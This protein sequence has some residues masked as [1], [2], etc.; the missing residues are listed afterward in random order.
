MKWCMWRT[1]KSAWD[2]ESTRK[3]RASTVKGY[4][5][6]S[7]LASVRRLL[8][9]W[10]GVNFDALCGPRLHLWNKGNDTPRLGLPVDVRNVC[11]QWV[12]AYLLPGCPFSRGHDTAQWTLGARAVLSSPCLLLLFPSCMCEYAFYFKLL[13]LL[14]GEQIHCSQRSSGGGGGVPAVRACE[15]GTKTSL[16]HARPFQLAFLLSLG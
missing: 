5:L 6:W 3:E 14:C 11:S 13:N 2:T 9:V 4:R 12:G 15:S 16:L 8:A 1:W 10:L 7:Q